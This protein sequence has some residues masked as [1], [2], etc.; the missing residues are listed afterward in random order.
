VGG[1]RTGARHTQKSRHKAGFSNPV[2][3]ALLDVLADQ[4]CHLEHGDLG[5][6]EDFLELGVGVDHALVGSVLQ[7]VGLDV[8]PQ[9]ADDF[10]A[11][12]G[13]EPTTAARAALGVRGFMKAALGVRFFAGAAGAAVAF[14]AVAMVACPC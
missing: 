1:G 13:V 14:F 6:A 7:V 10:G 3:D 9:L 11:W 12:Q 2:K 5:L 4:A 8:D